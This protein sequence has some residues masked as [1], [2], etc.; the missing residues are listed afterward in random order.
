MGSGS[1]N[2]NEERASAG[3]LLTKGETQILV[4]MGSGVR[5]NLY[6]AGIDD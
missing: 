6:R 3:V 5:A 1:P 2:Y 4:D